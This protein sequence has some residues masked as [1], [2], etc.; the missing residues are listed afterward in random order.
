[1]F[2][3][4]R[5]VAVLAA[6][7][8]AAPALAQVQTGSILVK[9]LD[10]QNAVMPGV[11]VTITSP[12][13]VAGSMTG[14]TDASG[15]YRFP[16][17][18]PGRYTVKT[19]LQGF[20]T[21]QREDV[22]VQVGQ[23]TPVDLALKVGALSETVT[24]S[25]ESPTVD[26]TSANVAVTLTS[27]ML[28]ATPGGRDIWALTEFK[29]P[30]LV[31]SRP[32]VGG[33][34]GG[35]QGTYTARG[36][37][38]QQNSQ[39]LNGVNVGDPSA[40]GAAGFYYDFDA[41]DEIQVSTGAHDITVPTSGVFL[42]MVTKSGGDKWAGQGAYY[43]S[44]HQ[45]Q[46]GNV[47]DALL[48]FG[49]K[50]ITG[51][52]NFVSDGTFQLG[53]PIVKD[54]LRLFASVRDWRVHV[55]T[56]AALSQTIVDNTD[57]TSGLVNLS[58][59]MNKANRFTAFYSRQYYKK[60][61]R[62]LT[63]TTTPS[64]N[65]T[66]DSISNEDD[67]F[68]VVQGLWNSVIT[69]RLFMDARV[70]FNN[71]NFP[72]KFNG[73]LTPLND[74]ST[75]ILLNNEQ[76][77]SLA[78]RRR[79]EANATFNYYLDRALGGRHEFKFGFDHAHAPVQTETDRWGDALLNYRSLPSGS[80]P[81]GP[82][83]V[84][85]FNTPVIS[86]SA[87]DITS[88]F[89]QDAY[90]V[91]NL[92]VT[93]GARVERLVSYLPDQSSPATQWAA[94]GIGG[95]PALPRTFTASNNII[96]WWNV[97]PRLSGVYDVT[98]DGKTAI[99]ASVARYYYVLNSAAVNPVNLNA[100]YSE[101]YSWTD[102]NGDLQF[103]PG[104][105]SGTPVVASA[106][107]TSFAPD[108]SRPYTNEVTAGLDREVP[109]NVKLSAVFTYRAEKNQQ[110]F[111]NAAAPFGTWPTRTA[112]DPGPDGR[113]GTADD[114]TVSYFDRVVGATQTVINN[115]PT[116]VQSYK[117][118]EI[119][120]TKRMSHRW[121]VLAGLTL[122][123][124]RQDDISENTSANNLVFGP[125]F[126]INDSGPISTDVPVQFKLSG[127][128]ILPYDISLAANFRSQSG[129][130]YN[131]Q[132]SVPMTLGGAATVNVEPFDADRVPAL[133]TLG[134]QASKNFTFSSSHGLTVYFTV[135][136]IT[137]ANTIWAVRNLTGLSSFRQAGDPNGAI[138]TVPQFGTPTNIIGP[139]IARIGASF[140]F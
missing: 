103:Q 96:N 10:E 33:T 14:V 34:S 30:G 97:G 26:T 105:Q 130:P 23:T 27:Q 132:V 25:G 114:S 77:Q 13:L 60:P 42:N 84:Q 140:R 116:L 82:T 98:G 71:I 100:T 66:S 51:A 124:S 32:D 56:P 115:D 102:K 86:R 111:V 110:A 44:G 81:A 63:S 11:T 108:F 78:I 7:G 12:V 17:L 109:G 126:I 127:S 73:T 58:Y 101:T 59:Q 38:S 91:K 94:D 121:Q 18:S 67:V 55:N 2:R 136:N 95:F 99:K 39:Y 90:T 54:K 4:L 49:F 46:N 89:V 19:E 119:T 107:Q 9:A 75:G 125:N 5:F 21:V 15:V 93:A 129:T 48:G 112:T 72:L 40:I 76:S 139:R 92:T 122:S 28:Q 37:T 65:F 62:F 128:Y 52:V 133:T 45:I 74:L 57:M 20:Q 85:L 134:V 135:D 113:T 61:H 29:V 64:T 117:G 41:F 22:V 1:M 131:R 106:A 79:L 70:S 36:T 88:L 53:G 69:Q 35:L 120:A 8:I 50:P 123:R 80:T 6:I 16:S 137:N 118:V 47:D 43:W 83:T 87:T 24:V 31:M 138:N 3:M 104:E 68:D